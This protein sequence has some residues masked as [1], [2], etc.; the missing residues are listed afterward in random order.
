MQP[1]GSSKSCTTLSG[2]VRSRLVPLLSLPQAEHV[3]G[4]PR[5]RMRDVGRDG[6]RHVPRTAAAKSSG[7]RNV[8]MA[9]DGER[10]R[11]ALHGGAEAG[12]PQHAA[13]ADVVGAEVAIEI[14]DERDAA[15][16][17]EDAGEVRGALLVAPDFL[18][19]PDVV[20]R[21]LADVPLAP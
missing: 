16:G 15:G 17:R 2:D 20:G 11:I 1:K 4:V 21:E 7:D 12:L 18:E 8:L 10:D 3:Q 5:A 19:R 6:R 13:G 14:A 9:V